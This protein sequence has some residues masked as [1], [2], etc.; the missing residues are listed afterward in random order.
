MP[1][2]SLNK[3]RWKKLKV[4]RFLLTIL[5]VLTT[6]TLPAHAAEDKPYVVLALSGGGV[7]GYAHIGVLEVLER[8]GVGIAGIV[9]TSMGS[10][11]GSLYASGKTAAE[12][13]SIVRDVNLAE[14][15]TATGGNYFNVSEKMNRDV[16]MIRP[17]MHMNN[18]NKLVGP[19]GLVA[20]T[21]VLEYIAQLLSHVTVTDFR[22]LPIPFAAVATDLVTG[23]K[24]VLRRG[25]L[26]SA[27]RASMSIP[28][29]FDPWEING[30]L[31]VDGGMVSNMPV[32]TARELFPG[33]PVIAINLTSELEPR[34]NL[35]SMI[36]VV[37]QSITI[38]TM[39]NVRREAALADLLI[40]PGV[41]SYPML[42]TNPAGEIIDQGRVAAE[43]ML[44]QLRKLLETAPRR[45]VKRPHEGEPQRP[46]HVV[47][48]RVT[49]V[50]AD[51]ARAMEREL[52]KVWIGREVPMKE[53]VAA[54]TSIAG[55]DDVRSV[56]YDLIHTERGVIVVLK[57]Q[58]LPP[59]IYRMGGYA[60]T[61]AS[62]GWLEI[63]GSSYD[64]FQ[65]GDMLT[66]RAYL[67]DN[68][69]ADFNYYW[70][71]D[72]RRSRYWE[73]NLTA[74]RFKMDPEGGQASWQ[75]Y[76]FDLRR[77]YVLGQRLRLSAG[78]AG[79]AFRHVSGAESGNYL[80]P[81][82]SASLNLMDDPEDPIN[83]FKFDF[84]GMWI[85][86]EDAF[87]WRAAMSGRRALNKNLV[88]ELQGGYSEGKLNAHMPL[89]AY[90]GAR[91]ELYSLAQHPIPSERFAWWR[92]KLRHPLQQTM[93]GPVVAEL[94]GGQGYAWGTGSENI[95]K[96]WEAGL[97]LHAPRKL[98][99]GKVYAVYTDRKEWK[100]GLTIG[101]PD[102]DVFHLF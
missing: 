88:A 69:A 66:S 91:E 17:E 59:H 89:A 60:S 53:V 79:G 68:W 1:K 74:A 27:V 83:G 101:V 62:K 80:A 54:S 40:S 42:G 73:A 7:K 46:P 2:S 24:V 55:R 28:G 67:G 26:A 72:V 97:A 51:M 81:V 50:P 92:V 61:L 16:S 34:E 52:L 33:Y 63:S 44:P 87:L 65:P 25:S 99:D 37:S 5:L 85:G 6:L 47:G 41:K 49:G 90:L 56:D 75:K 29:V 31:L 14:L 95:R 82:F 19:L 18:Q 98:I 78:L 58:R 9:G 57:V 70:G 22:R 21:A 84:N 102:W 10:I 15:V 13:D 4:K 86:S 23:E 100:F 76:S 32:E 45:P 48:V 39:Q 20:G 11:V 36:D 8:E 71:M 3:T 38:L 77:H 35:G 30:R 43:K 94:F 64:L 93:F 96:P 12:L